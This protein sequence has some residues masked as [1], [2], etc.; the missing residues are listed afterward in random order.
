MAID[1]VRSGCGGREVIFWSFIVV[2]GLIGGGGI[3]GV[4]DK[5]GVIGDNGVVWLG[6]LLLHRP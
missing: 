5:G 3:G 1:Q 6:S 2:M 4:D